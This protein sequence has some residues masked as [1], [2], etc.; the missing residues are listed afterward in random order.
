MKSDV[1]HSNHRLATILVMILLL[2]LPLATFSTSAGTSKSATGNEDIGIE[3]EGYASLPNVRAFETG[4]LVNW[5]LTWAGVDYSSSNLYHYDYTVHTGYANNGTMTYNGSGIGFSTETGSLTFSIPAFELWNNNSYEYTLRIVLWDQ[6]RNQLLDFVEEDF[7]IFQS[8][9]TSNASKLLVFGDSLSDMGNSKA[10]YGTPESPPYYSGRFSNGPMWNEHVAVGMGVSITPGVGSASGPN[11]AFGGAEAGDGL[12]FF[13]IPNLG[14]QIEDYT[15]N[16]WIGPNEKVAVWGG[17]N[18]FLNSGETDTQKVVNYIVN[19]VN[20]LASNGARDI[21]VLNMPPLE[22]TP[23]YSGE[24]D[25]SKQAMHARMIDYNTKLDVAMTARESALNISI[26]LIDIFEMFETI[27]RNSSF[28]GLSNVTHAACHHQGYTCESG[29]YIE[30]TV[31]EFIFFDKIHPTGTT[32]KLLGMYILEQIGTPDTDGD[33]IENNADNCPKTPVGDAVNHFGCRLVDLDSDYDGVNDLLDQCPGTTVGATVDEN[34]CADYQKDTDQDGVTD[35]IDLCPETLAN[36]EVDS[37]GCADYQKDTDQDGVTDDIDLC[38][39]TDAGAEINLI[40]CAQNQID[41]DWDG[42]M[43][44]ADQCPN[45]PFDEVVDE[46]GCSLSQLDSDEDGV[47]DDLDLCPDTPAQSPVDMNG[48]ALTQLDSDSDG[49]SDAIDICDLTPPDE[50]ANEVGCSPTQRDS[51]GDGRNDALDECPLSAG[52]IRGCPTM[53]LSVQVIHWPESYNDTA[54][55]IVN[56]SC[57][58]DYLFTTIFANETLLN[59]S[60]GETELQIPP[61]V[62]EFELVLRIEHGVSWMEKKISLT[63]P[64]APVIETDSNAASNGPSSDSSDTTS[65][66]SSGT[67]EAESWQISTTVEYLL[68]ILIFIGIGLTVGTIIRT[69]RRPSQPRLNW[70][71]NPSSLSTLEVERELMNQP[72]IISDLSPAERSTDLENE[73]KSE[74]GEIPSIDGL[75]D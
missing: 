45:T 13:V 53:A 62:G 22:K 40:G 38:P 61:H 71:D 75:L 50:I 6:S 10:T 7:V 34:G 16:Y 32:H 19:H 3:M 73:S 35:N 41:S 63:W 24:S 58:N 70:N 72:Q 51:D 31:D 17:G 2:L 28:Y 1:A 4:E 37:D 29:D 23:T 26:Q 18:N 49:V 67:V 25:S 27:Y 30:P 64:E 54:I 14:K 8:S 43:N 21:I 68:G 15:N 44:D 9:V 46:N 48:C 55:L 66:G 56:T 39:N 20:D 12:N 5:N 11:R 60:A 74:I 59:Q 69:N 42:V 36:H 47:T 33:G 65:D 57:E 52:S